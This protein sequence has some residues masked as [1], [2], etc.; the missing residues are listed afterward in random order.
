MYVYMWFR[1]F[2]YS[3]YIYIEREREREKERKSEI[4]IEKYLFVGDIIYI[5]IY[6]ER[7]R[8]Q[9]RAELFRDVVADVLD[10]DILMREFKPLSGH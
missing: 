8:L 9:E 6:W 7:E 10:C 3:L 2:T 4:E 5:Y 1:V